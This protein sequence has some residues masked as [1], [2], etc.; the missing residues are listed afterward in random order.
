MKKSTLS[1]YINWLSNQY[2]TFKQSH[3]KEATYRLVEVE[4]KEG[5]CILTLQVIGKAITLQ[6]SP[7]EILAND[8][9]LDCFSPK[10]VRTITY[11]GTKGLHSSKKKITAKSLSAGSSE[12][13]FEVKDIRKGSITQKT[14]GEISSDLE[15]LRDLT[16]EEAHQIGYV[17][18][19]DLRNAE[20]L[21][22]EALKKEKKV[23]N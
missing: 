19:E 22:M 14:A 10:D 11:Y 1:A 9:W 20:K 2:Q 21:Q 4:D 6:S 23:K 16:P 18:A 3:R 13:V 7:E 15:F 12:T 17:A 5:K 8:T